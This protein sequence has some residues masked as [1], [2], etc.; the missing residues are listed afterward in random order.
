MRNRTDSLRLVPPL[1]RATHAI[2]LYLQALH[3]EVSQGEAHVLAHL[4]SEGPSTISALHS[5]FGHRRST[6]TSILD[7][8][9]AAELVRRDVHPDDRRSFLISLTESG[10]SLAREVLQALASLEADVRDRVEAHDLAGYE[11][12]VAALQAA[13][14]ESRGGKKS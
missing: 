4:S 12:V 7:R 3:L 10:Q 2:G 13:A 6:L 8:L 5:A 11:A 14:I 1:H 9:A